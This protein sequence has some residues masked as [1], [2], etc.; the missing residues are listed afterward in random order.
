MG[1]I[2][3]HVSA[4]G[5][6]AEAARRAAELGLECLQLFV[7]SPQ[8]WKSAS[9]GDGEVAA[10]VAAF[11]ANGLQPIFIHA[12]YLINLAS[13]RKEVR[14]MSRRLLG[15][16]LRWADRLG[17][18]GVVVHV[19]SGGDDAFEQVVNDLRA[20]LGEHAGEA[21][22]ILE[23]D[24]G[25][26]RRIGSR[27]AELGELIA[28]LDGDPRLRVCVDTAHAL[29]SGYEL[30]TPEGLDAA[31]DELGASVGLKR[32]ALL[33]VNDSK[34]DLGSHVDRHE[35]L[36]RG[37]IGVSAFARILTHPALRDL[38]F[39]LEVPGYAG[40]GPDAPNVAALRILAGGS[41]DIAPPPATPAE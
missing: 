40:E 34:T 21:A 11:A 32:V 20:V 26:G 22:L 5:G 30:R 10:G 19:G 33:H 12:S 27:L 24:A 2:G 3:A 17:A 16:Q 37:K 29:A 6:P 28:A 15:E 35:N 7:G 23:N 13:L 1:R 31:V 25:S 4:A 36:G 39:V 8:T 14:G 41:A 38:P 18:L 9:L